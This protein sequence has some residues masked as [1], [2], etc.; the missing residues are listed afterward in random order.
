MG[1][2]STKLIERSGDA[3]FKERK[4]AIIGAWR[5]WY[6]QIITAM[7]EEV[8]HEGLGSDNLVSGEMGALQ[9]ELDHCRAVG[10]VLFGFMCDDSDSDEP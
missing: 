6:H 3:A 4:S 5:T 10:G 1:N 8:R 7:G 2:L 9:G